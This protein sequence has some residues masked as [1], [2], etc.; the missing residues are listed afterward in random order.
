MRES[1]NMPS[2][3]GCGPGTDCRFELP[4]QLMVRDNGLVRDN[5]QWSNY[6]FEKGTWRILLTCHLTFSI[7]F[8]IRGENGQ[9]DSRI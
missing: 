3:P 9:T 4:E 1:S 5:G 6:C 8:A 7:V 2:S